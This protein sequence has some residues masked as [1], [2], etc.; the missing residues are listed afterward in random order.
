M[1]TP[2][3]FTL[4]ELIVVVALVAI[5]A[6]VAVPNFNQLVESNRVTSHTNSVVGAMSYARAE[7]VR[8]GQ[9]VAVVPVGGDYANGLSVQAGGGEL[10]TVEPPPN[11]ITLA[12]TSGAA[13]TFRANGMSGQNVEVRYL[14][15]GDP[16]SDGTQITVTLGGQVR[17]ADAV[18]P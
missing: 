4:I 2:R 11:S 13:M 15:C 12:M 7:A 17:T 3:G 16:G 5:I 18:C 14:V 8:R 10:R 6:A 1:N 9:T